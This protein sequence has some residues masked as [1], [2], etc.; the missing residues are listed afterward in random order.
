MRKTFII[1]KFNSVFNNLYIFLINVKL[2]RIKGRQLKS[3]LRSERIN[4]NF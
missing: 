3:S 2:F 1:E 4:E